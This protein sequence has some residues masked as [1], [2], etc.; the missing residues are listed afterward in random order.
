MCQSYMCLIPFIY[1]V[2]ES[3]PKYRSYDATEHPIRE[4]S[5]SFSESWMKKMA[6]LE[7]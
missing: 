6:C 5:V 4:F 1:M 2:Y 7:Q 3:L